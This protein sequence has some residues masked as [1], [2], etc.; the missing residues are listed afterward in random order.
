MI[1]KL[2]WFYLRFFRAIFSNK[3]FKKIKCDE[4]KIKEIHKC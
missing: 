1:Y 2:Y 3:N 4:I